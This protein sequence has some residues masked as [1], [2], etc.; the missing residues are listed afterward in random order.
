MIITVK[1]GKIRVMAGGRSLYE[2]IIGTVKYFGHIVYITVP[3][4]RFEADTI[5]TTERKHQ[6][7]L[8][9]LFFAQKKI[10]RPFETSGRLKII[11]YFP[12]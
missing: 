4:G 6:T 9:L 12:I 3:A 2:Q 1:M 11:I 10:R 5:K 8:T 7:P